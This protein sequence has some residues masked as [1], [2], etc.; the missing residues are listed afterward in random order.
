MRRVSNLGPGFTVGCIVFG[1][2]LAASATPAH[3]LEQRAATPEIPRKLPDGYLVMP[4]VNESGLR[5][6]DWMRV[7]LPVALAEKLEVHPGL[8][9][10]YASETVVAA[11][12]YDVVEAARV[13]GARYVFTGAYK[14]PNWKLQID[15][16]LWSVEGATKVLVGERTVRG[17][18]SDVY[19]LLDDAL[20]SLCAAAGHPVP[21]AATERLA[22]LPTKDFYAFTLYG[23]GLMA[24]VGLDGAPDLAKAEKDLSRSV[25][26]DPLFAEGH[27]MLAV[28]YLRLGQRGKARGRLS[29]ALDLRADYYAPLALLVRAA[30]DG[31]ERG[32]GIELAT[33]ALHL[34]PWDHDVRYMLGDLLWEE[35]D[36]EGARLEL[37]RL[38]AVQPHHLA[39]RRIL[40]LVHAAQGNMADLASELEAIIELDPEDER[41]KLDLGAAYHALGNDA[42]ARS[43]YE[44]IVERNPKHIQALKFIGDIHRAQGELA[45]A[46]SWYERALAA[47]RND[48]RPYFLLGSAYV[49]AGD[50]DKALRIYHAA[51][52]FPRYLGETYSNLGAL[53][54]KRGKNDQALWY[55]KTAAAKKPQ[56]P[57]VRYNYGLALSRAH[58]RDRALEEMTAATELD[59]EEADFQFGLG[60]ALLRLGRLEEAE[61]AFMAA[62]RL[63]PAHADAAHNLQLI[64]ELRRR[65]QEGEIQVE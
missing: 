16:K 3:A 44:A 30:Y 27:R 31:K 38:T 28:A 6:L 34:R 48:P 51:V 12:G 41:A 57:R 5:S 23:R 53:Y 45:T 46:I 55:L 29:Y 33:R 24:L 7:G 49:S 62:V 20:T 54:Y 39:A 13:A 32:E 26:I 65:A 56:N 10:A 19:D 18:F 1:A 15:V 37:A 63:D 35:G 21:T 2:L 60:V 11:D 8:R 61:K 25:Y 40:V 47:N 50:E 4:F 22:R 43:I 52:R 14:R 58:V 36:A 59:P 9:A 17:D 42:R 64:E